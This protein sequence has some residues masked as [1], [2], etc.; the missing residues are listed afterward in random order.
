MPLFKPKEIT[1]IV[2][3][4][5]N[6]F[7][8]SIKIVGEDKDWYSLSDDLNIVIGKTSEDFAALEI[9]N[10]SPKFQIPNPSVDS[11]RTFMERFC[12]LYLFH[13]VA[14]IAK[15]QMGQLWLLENSDFDFDRKSESI[16][17]Y[18]TF[19][20][21][22]RYARYSSNGKN[23]DLLANGF[24][25][26]PIY[27]KGLDNDLE[28]IRRIKQIQ[29]SVKTSARAME[30]LEGSMKRTAMIALAPKGGDTD[31]PLEWDVKTDDEKIEQ[32]H[33]MNKTHSI[34]EGYLTFFDKAYDV[35]NLTVD[36]KKL[37]AIETMDQ[38]KRNMCTQI[39]RPYKMDA[40][41]SKFDDLELQLSQYYIGVLQKI[42]DKFLLTVNKI[43]GSNMIINCE[44]DLAKIT[45]KYNKDENTDTV[46]PDN[47]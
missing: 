8:S 5:V 46:Q 41:D 29:G 14:Y 17:K 40:A 16:F 45:D 11:Y 33:R 23:V 43:L 44:N 10:L 4:V 24:E 18:S 6:S 13:S 22:L 31:I 3:R 37:Q 27:D 20:E 1:K 30:A 39:G 15:S 34:K 25:I 38:C 12:Y 36:N 21:S 28:P 47:Q 9:E 19:T 26:Y 2:N 35:L 42:A 7:G 32:R